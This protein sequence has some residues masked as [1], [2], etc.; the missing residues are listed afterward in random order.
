MALGIATIFYSVLTAYE[1]GVVSI[2]PMPVHL[3]LDA[4]SGLALALSPFLF[5]FA[6]RI[7]TP[8]ILL[9]LFEILFS[10]ITRTR[11]GILPGPE[12]DHVRGSAHGV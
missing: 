1:L 11:A 8:Y 3:V 12:N 2:V 6:G 7:A 5:G 10:L 4:L 9:G